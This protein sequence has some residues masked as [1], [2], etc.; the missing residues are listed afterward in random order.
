M[1][2]SPAFKQL[3][4]NG[5]RM[6]LVA[7]LAALYLFPLV[8]IFSMSFMSASELYASAPS[9]F[10]KRSRWKITAAFFRAT[11]QFSHF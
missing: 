6:L 4:Q 2:I 7:V 10:P 1:S 11:F 3:R 5:L 9:I 8:R